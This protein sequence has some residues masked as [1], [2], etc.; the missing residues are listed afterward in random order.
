MSRAPEQ[1][2]LIEARIIREREWMH[3]RW[4]E[5]MTFR[6]IAAAAALPED[7]GGLGIRVSVEG[8]R[9]MVQTHRREQGDLTLSIDERRERQSDE[10]DMRVRAARRDLDA[11]YRG[12]EQARQELAELGPYADPAERVALLKTIELHENAIDRA[13]RRLDAAQVRE[14]K[15][16]GLAAPVKVEADV[17]HRD[18]VAEELSAMML[19]LGV[20]VEG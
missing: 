7:R 14:D 10:V 9:N 12:I 1:T 17:T 15:L 20:D 6:Q 2:A 3:A 5:R 18:A 19:R 4:M 8:V 13:D 16:H 11:A